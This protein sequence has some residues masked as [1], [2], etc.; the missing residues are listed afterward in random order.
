MESLIT[1]IQQMID[2]TGAHAL[3]DW[4]KKQFMAVL[5]N[6]RSDSPT[7]ETAVSTS[8]KITDWYIKAIYADLLHKRFEEIGPLSVEKMT[9]L[10]QKQIPLEKQGVLRSIT[11]L[12]NYFSH[13]QSDTSEINQHTAQGCLLMLIGFIQSVDLQT[14][15][16]TQAARNKNPSIRITE[17]APLALGIDV[18]T[19]KI[20]V[21]L[22]SFSDPTRPRVLAK[23]KIFHREIE[24]ELGLLGAIERVSSALVADC[25]LT[26]KDLTGVGVGLPGQVNYRTGYLH[27]APGLNLHGVDVPTSLAHRLGTSVYADNDVNCSTLAELHWGKGANFSDFV[28]IF[29]G[30]GIGAGLVFDR[31]LYRGAS[32]AAGEVGHMKVAT[33]SNAQLCTCGARGCFEEYASARAIV[34]MARTEI[35]LARERNQNTI[36]ATFDPETLTPEHIVDAIRRHD[37]LGVELAKRIAESLAVGISNV[38]NLLNPEAIILGG[39]IINGFY[40]FDF[41]STL[42]H[43]KFKELTLDI[44]GTTPIMAATYSG[45]DCPMLGA[46]SLVAER[47]LW[48]ASQAG[49]L[50][51]H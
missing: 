12:Q 13:S 48:K 7:Y 1:T 35:F 41:F 19:N 29:V 40:D 24:S 33:D 27:F 5:H 36:L 38:A 25:G 4:P 28:C 8:R 44:S 17:S 49:Q 9:Q 22:I 3:P 6:L 39:G 21:G 18:G 51:G 32:F 20:A 16:L 10:L 45:E 2:E 47:Q 42:V 23:T 14:P 37:E 11:A 31:K 50:S 43:A 46:A 26:F 15:S 30:T 34:R